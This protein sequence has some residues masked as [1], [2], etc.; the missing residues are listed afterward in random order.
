MHRNEEGRE[1]HFSG[2]SGAVI[3]SMAS[4]TSDAALRRVRLYSE[5]LS[6]QVSRYKER[7]DAR[8]TVMRGDELLGERTVHLGPSDAGALLG[9]ELRLLGRD[10]VYESALKRAVEILD[11]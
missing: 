11:L 6:F 7:T 4:N 1:L 8:C 2:P 10:E 3:V 5:E 9:E